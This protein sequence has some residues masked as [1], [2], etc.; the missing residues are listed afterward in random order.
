MAY[1][2]VRIA[3]RAL[4]AIGAK[5]GIT[6]LPDPSNPNAVKVNNIWDEIVDGVLADV[7]PRFATLRAALAQSGTD[8][9]NAD[10]WHYAY[11]LPSDYL[12]PAV[13]NADDPWIWPAGIEPYSI[14]TLSS[15]DESLCVMTNYDSSSADDVYVL[16]IRRVTDP[17]KYFPAFQ[18]CLAYRLAAELALSVV[19]SITKHQDMMTLYERALKKAKAVDRT[20]LYIENEKK[21]LDA[22]ADAGR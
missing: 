12:C 14:E 16:Y 13:D 8:P 2:K 5:G 18:T 11:P 4:Q 15:S 10:Q 7:K 9:T 1:S 3:N 17:T 19:E 6:T 21:D 22:W 20:Q